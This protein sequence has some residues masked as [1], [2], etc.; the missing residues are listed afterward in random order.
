MVETRA[1]EVGDLAFTCGLAG[2]SN[3]PPV[4][5]LH[6]FPQ[7]RWAWRR[8]LEALAQAGFRAIAP[9]QRGY[10]PGARPTETSAYAA[11]NIVGDALGI[12]D[13]LGADHFHL[14]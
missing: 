7:S 10:S 3:G 2:P 4:L 14:I 11:A 1:I 5:M 8:Q 12:M 6:G 13:A 9:D